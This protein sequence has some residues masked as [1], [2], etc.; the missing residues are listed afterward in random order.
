MKHINTKL[1]FISQ[2]NIADL[3]KVVA[4]YTLNI[5]LRV[6]HDLLV[7]LANHEGMYIAAPRVYVAKYK[8][9]FMLHSFHC[10]LVHAYFKSGVV[11]YCNSTLIE[12]HDS[13]SVCIAHLHAQQIFA[14]LDCL[15][16]L[17]LIKDTLDIS[18]PNVS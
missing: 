8:Q 13:H 4:Y 15:H 16:F 2:K 1:V 14:L 12:E 17:F 6:H 10:H 18:N 9:S 3:P 7:R 5:G 11:Y